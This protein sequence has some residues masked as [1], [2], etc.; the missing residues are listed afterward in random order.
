MYNTKP[1]YKIVLLYTVSLFVCSEIMACG[2]IH[3]SVHWEVKRGLCE[4]CTLQEI[5]WISFG[6]KA[7]SNLEKLGI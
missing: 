7:G 3:G 2:R 5:G 4:E 6:V 1:F